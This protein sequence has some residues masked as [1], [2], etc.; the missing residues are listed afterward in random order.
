VLFEALFEEGLVGALAIQ[1][2]LEQP[3]SKEHKTLLLDLS[4]SL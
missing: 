3:V 2:F 4:L 1:Q